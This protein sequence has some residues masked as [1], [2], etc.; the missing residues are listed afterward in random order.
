MVVAVDDRGTDGHRS[1]GESGN[2]G[3]GGKQ[4]ANGRWRLLTGEGRSGSPATNLH[5]KR[6]GDP[7][8]PTD[9][10][11][12]MFEKYLDLEL[13]VTGFACAQAIAFLLLLATDTK[14]LDQT[15]K[16]ASVWVPFI[17]MAISTIVYFIIIFW[18]RNSRNRCYRVCY[19][20]EPIPNELNRLDIKICSIIGCVNAI[21]AVVL[22]YISTEL[23][24]ALPDW[25]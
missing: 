1:R 13:S 6:N 17:G 5:P 10:A 4:G 24:M 9:V 14:R 2:G 16:S 21:L 23:R 3:A 19:P 20:T 25:T 22:Y 8:M 15:F 12:K 11:R 7:H 18:V